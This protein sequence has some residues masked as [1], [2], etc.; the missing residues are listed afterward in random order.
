MVLKSISQRD[1]SCY[2]NPIFPGRWS[3]FINPKLTGPQYIYI[4]MEWYNMLA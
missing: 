2:E 1:S 3:M 4:Y